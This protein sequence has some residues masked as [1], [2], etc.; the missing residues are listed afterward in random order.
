VPKKAK[1]HVLWNLQHSKLLQLVLMWFNCV[2]LI[3]IYHLVSKCHLSHIALEF[4]KPKQTKNFAK[5][6]ARGTY[7]GFLLPHY[8]YDA[9]YKFLMCSTQWGGSFVSQFE[10]FHNYCALLRSFKRCWSPFWCPK[11]LKIMFCEICSTQNCCNWSWCGLFVLYSL[12]S[13]IWYQNYIFPILHWN[14]TCQNRRKIRPKL[15]REV[16]KYLGFL[17][18]Y[19]TYNAA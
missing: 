16:L 2:V 12:I 1:N 5:N 11:K 19:H 8:T 9:T 13:I 14:F 10:V 6:E 17:L 18:P 3:D 4:Y 15:R 7:L